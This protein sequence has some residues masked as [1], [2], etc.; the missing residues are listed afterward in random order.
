MTEIKR[1]G[2]S[3]K[4]EIVPPIDVKTQIKFCK[5]QFVSYDFVLNRF[6][7]GFYKSLNDPKLI[8]EYK[9]V[10]DRCRAAAFILLMQ[11][12][13]ELDEYDIGNEVPV[14]IMKGLAVFARKYGYYFVDVYRE[15]EDLTDQYELEALSMKSCSADFVMRKY[16]KATAAQIKEEARARA[17]FSLEEKLFLKIPITHA[18]KNE[19]N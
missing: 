8:E 4:N 3:N 1:V 13:K 17:Y 5:E 9:D 10:D 11:V 12:T 14:W 6:M 7:A 18:R 16:S 2:E 15:F 19:V